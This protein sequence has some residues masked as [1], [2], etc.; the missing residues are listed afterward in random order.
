MALSKF[1]KYAEYEQ[2]IGEDLI[3][4]IQSLK[5]TIEILDDEGAD[6]CDKLEA[7]AK[8]I[9]QLEKALDKACEELARINNTF[10]R[11]VITT[12]SYWKEW[13]LK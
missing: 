13:C 3:D 2:Q 12:N 11:R 9:K 4:H 7:Q 6:K 8:K 10:E 1:I 5:R